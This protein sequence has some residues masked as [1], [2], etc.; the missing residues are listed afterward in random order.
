V[1][2][3]S[4][5]AKLSFVTKGSYSTNIGSRMYLLRDESHY[6]MFKLLNKEFTFS[7]DVSNLPCG[8]NG[9]LYFVEMEEDGGM[10]KHS[11]NKAGAKY[12]TGYCDAQCP[13]DLKFIEGLANIN[14]WEPSDNDVNAGNGGWG[15]CCPE[16]DI[17]ESNSQATAYTPHTC[18]QA[19]PVRCEGNGCG[20][21]GT[22]TRYTSECDPD[23]CDFN[24]WRM[25]DKTYFGPGLTVD[26]SKPFTV[27]TQFLTDGGDSGNLVEIRRKY[28]QGG[29]V[30]E[31]SFT[32]IDGITKADSITTTFCTEQ[33]KA[34]GDQNDFEKKGGMSGMGKAMG[35]GMVLVISLWDD[36]AVS[37]LWLDSS[38]P[39]DK[40]GPG[41]ERGPCATSSGK[42]TDVE[43]N[44]P[45]ASVIYSDIKFGPID[46]TY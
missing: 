17:W 27:V 3:N 40:S 33:K 29:K 7:V 10:A 45:D 24:S 15:S 5:A 37:M 26:T 46:S 4:S 21:Q 32:N 34:F 30:I 8:L 11:I 23:G 41:V 20:E 35:R 44:S 43:A 22:G 1:T 42:P 13:S 36:H 31:N 25:G 6:Q 38:Y 9:A 39:T 2:G 12:G 19:G 18:Q 28:V 16:L 14:G